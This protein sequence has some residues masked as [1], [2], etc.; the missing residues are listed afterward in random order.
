MWLLS[1]PSYLSMLKPRVVILENVPDLRAHRGGATF[2]SLLEGL[3]SPGRRLRYRLEHAIYDS[4][5]HGTPQVRRRLFI[6]A[7][8]DGQERLPDSDPNLQELYRAIRRDSDIPQGMRA[9][10]DELRD[11]QNARMV[12]SD[13]ALSDLPE[14]GPGQVERPLRFLNGSSTPVRGRSALEGPNA[15]QIRQAR[16]PSKQAN[17]AAMDARERYRPTTNVRSAPG[18]GARCRGSMDRISEI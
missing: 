4:A 18:P 17:T 9:F 13:Q 10:A 14:L 3:R 8:R 16:R 5:Q 6:L 1:V 12:T 15:R 11:P 7:V 2:R